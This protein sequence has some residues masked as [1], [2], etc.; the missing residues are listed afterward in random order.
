MLNVTYLI[1]NCQA[2][3]YIDILMGIYASLYFFLYNL[4]LY[5]AKYF[6]IYLKYIL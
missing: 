2:Y 3:T 5:L 6:P 1:R 4:A